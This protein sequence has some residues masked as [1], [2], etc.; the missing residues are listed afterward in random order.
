MGRERGVRVSWGVSAEMVVGFVCGALVPGHVDRLGLKEHGM[1]GECRTRRGLGTKRNRRASGLRMTAAVSSEGDD[2][3][4]A[5]VVADGKTAEVVGSESMIGADPVLD[6]KYRKW[7]IRT[8]YS[9]FL[10]YACFYF[11]RNSFTYTAPG[12]RAALGLSLEQ[13]GVITS[14]F[15]LAYGFS[16]LISGVLADR[17][18]ESY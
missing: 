7:R 4:K 18:V 12:M 5:R 1:G 14:V 9:I 16:K 17:Y 6:A 11:T 13:L 3:S 8:F 15:P 2:V 10:G